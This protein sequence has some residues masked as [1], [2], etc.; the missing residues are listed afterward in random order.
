MAGDDMRGRMARPRRPEPVLAA[1][2]APAPEPEPSPVAEPETPRPAP[3]S[4]S[5]TDLA[6]R[7]TLALELLGAPLPPVRLAGAGAGRRANKLG[8]AIDTE[9]ESEA[10][11]GRTVRLFRESVTTRLNDPE[12]TAIVVVMQRL[13]ERD[14][15][16]IILA[17]GLGYEHLMLPMRMEPER[18]C[19]T[20]IGFV[21][22][23]AARPP[24]FPAPVSGAAG[25]GG[26]EAGGG[27]AGAA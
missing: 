3:G 15:S 16:G 25:G 10:E 2:V 8:H 6:S 19:A 9:A 1:T 26:A 7:L 20:R 22:R 18:R 13:H 12:R 17:E 4:A 24:P 11:R 5:P 21:D 27:A 14:I 23:R